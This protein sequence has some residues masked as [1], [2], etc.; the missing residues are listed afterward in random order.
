M[1]AHIVHIY[2]NTE[3]KLSICDPQSGINTLGDNGVLHYLKQVKPTTIKLLDVQNYDINMNV[4]N[5][6]LQGVKK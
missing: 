3:G 2:K 1:A 4:V 6:I 5:K